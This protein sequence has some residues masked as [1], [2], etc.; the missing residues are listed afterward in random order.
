[1]VIDAKSANDGRLRVGDMTTV[2]AQGP[3]HR[4]RVV[5]IV[6][7]GTADSPGGA[8]VALFT[9]PVAQRLVAAPG[10]LTGV[11]FVARAGVSQQQLAA[12]LRH[13]LPHGLE[14]VTG[15]TITKEMQDSFQQALAF[16][17]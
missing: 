17:R 16:W 8:S 13:E 10:K 6:R 14:A 11:L 3:P 2:L 1:V 12:N 15:A 9:T 7:F 4:Y 5:G